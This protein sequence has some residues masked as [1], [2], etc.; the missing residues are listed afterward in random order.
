MYHSHILFAYN[1]NDGVLPQ[2]IKD[3]HISHFLKNDGLTWVHLDLNH[4]DTRTWLHTEVS[5]LDSLIIDALLADETRPRI[6]SVN[7][8]VF[9]NLRGINLNQGASPSDM[10]SIRLW[11]DKTRIIS[12]QRRELKAIYDIQNLV[13]NDATN[14]LIKTSGDFI[15]LLIEKLLSDIAPQITTIEEKMDIAEEN[16]IHR[17]QKSLRENILTIRTQAISY[18]RYLLPQR[19]IIHD[20]EAEN[21]TFIDKNNKRKL[22]ENY[23]IITRYIEDLESL[24]ERSQIIKDELSNALSDTLNRNLYILSV[25]SAIFLPL[26]F[27]AGLLGV[28]LAGIPYANNGMAFGAFCGLL[29]IL[30]LIQIGFF[31]KY[32]IF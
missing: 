20:L 13:M 10:V 4:N 31:K 2:P 28:N 21:L 1:L 12:V 23:D 29:L 26:H 25:V 17:P 19:D 15:C 7:N 5:Y 18:R 32:K 6:T 9:I 27:F 30:V 11:I 22:H 16:V 14:H 3:N 8:G 24:R